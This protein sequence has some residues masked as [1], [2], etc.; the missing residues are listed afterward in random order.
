MTRETCLVRC[1]TLSIVPF[2]AAW[3][4]ATSR[5]EGPPPAP[6]PYRAA[7]DVI[8]ERDLEAWIGFLAAAELEGRESGSR[9]YDVACRYAASFFRSLGLAPGG[10]DGSFY[11]PFS[12]LERERQ[13]GDAVLTV[14]GPSGEEEH[15]SLEGEFAV[16]SRRSIRWQGPWVFAGPGEGADRDARDDFHGLPLKEH[17]VLI[18]PPRGR[19]SGE[20]RGAIAAGAR[21]LVIVSDRRVRSRVGVRMRRRGVKEAIE[22][23]EAADD[24]VLA[25][26]EIV[27]LS[28]KVADRLLRRWELSVE[29]LQSSP[30]SAPRRVLPG[31]ELEL[32][33]GLRRTELRTQNVV[34]VL[35]GADPRLRSEFIVIGGHLDHVGAR[36]GKVFNGAD[37]N[38]SGSAAILAVAKAMSSLETRPR[39]S[40]AFVL[41]GAEEIG[42]LG[43][44]HF[45][46][47]PPFP[48]EKVVT[49]INLDMVGRNEGGS[50]VNSDEKPEDN[51]NS[52]N[53]IGSKRASNELDPWIQRVNRHVGL[54]FEYD[55]E[56]N[57]V[58]RRSDHYSFARQGVAVV[59]FFAGFHRD[60]HQDTDTADKLNYPK[61]ARVARL[62]L[63]LAYEIADRP[64]RLVL[65]RV[66]L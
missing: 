63:A 4:P 24:A 52:L 66:R 3:L 20:A 11:Q 1:F 17:V 34:A 51:E 2:V 48:M 42:L 41:F 38:A 56:E 32:V 26:A 6:L 47:H 25:G 15:I 54:D 60:Y 45:V 46:E 29:D 35:E 14:H 61:V 31:A 30:G 23:R 27:Y 33:V 50:R 21:R 9:G 5:G 7:F 40:V 12:L 22:R 10:S 19:T 53:V 43:S 16:R 37:D 44:R 39:R 58:W 8:S 49:M 13:E 57:R 18:V 36:E 59:F 55:Q 62:T 65:H 64:E 28:T